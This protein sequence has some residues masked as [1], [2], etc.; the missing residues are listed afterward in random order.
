MHS[1]AKK[2]GNSGKCCNYQSVSRYDGLEGRS[3]GE[4]ATHNLGPMECVPEGYA[5]TQS[6]HGG[7]EVANATG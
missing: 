4:K 2:T 6:R 7:Q 3:D 1:W 5:I